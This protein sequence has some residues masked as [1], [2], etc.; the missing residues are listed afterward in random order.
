[1]FAELRGDVRFD[2]VLEIQFLRKTPLRCI[3]TVRVDAEVEPWEKY[4]AINAY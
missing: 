1:M 3:E 2:C 4:F